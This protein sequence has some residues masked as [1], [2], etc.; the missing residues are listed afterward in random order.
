MVLRD[1]PLMNYR[2][3]PNWP[4]RWLPRRDHAGELHGEFGVLTE[5]DMGREAPHQPAQLFL[6]MNHNGR[7]YVSAV[8]FSDGTFCRQLCELLKKY[9]GRTIEEVGGLDLRGLL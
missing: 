4:P 2:G 6:F 9:Y 5:V 3:I 7:E 8:L 1:H